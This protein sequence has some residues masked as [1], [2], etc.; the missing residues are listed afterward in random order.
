MSAYTLSII[1]PGGKVYKSLKLKEIKSGEREN[2][3]GLINYYYMYLVDY[4]FLTY[5]ADQA[6]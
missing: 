3:V 6:E 2:P 5:S 1:E 4:I